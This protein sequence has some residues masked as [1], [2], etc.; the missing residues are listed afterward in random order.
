VSGFFT[1]LPVRLLACSFPGSFT[2]WHNVA[3]AAHKLGP[4]FRRSAVD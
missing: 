2:P 4:L 1:P 3:P